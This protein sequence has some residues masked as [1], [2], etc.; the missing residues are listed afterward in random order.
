[1]Q[2]V[3]EQSWV[4]NIDFSLSFRC[5]KSPGTS[6]EVGQTPRVWEPGRWRVLHKAFER[7]QKALWRFQGALGRLQEVLEGFWAEN[8]DFALIFNG[9][10]LPEIAGDQF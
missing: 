1:M 8:I 9:F 7:L 2:K 5:W 10:G 3:L 4:E 6:F